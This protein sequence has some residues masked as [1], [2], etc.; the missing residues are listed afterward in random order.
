MLIAFSESDLLLTVIGVYLTLA[1]L[2]L[3]YWLFERV[4]NRD[5]EPRP[6]EGQRYEYQRDSDRHRAQA[7]SPQSART[8]Q[9]Q[10][11]VA[12]AKEPWEELTAATE[13]VSHRGDV[14]RLRQE[15]CVVRDHSS[16]TE[17]RL[18]TLQAEVEGLKILLSERLAALEPAEEQRNAFDR[19]ALSLYDPRLENYD[20]DWATIDSDLGVILAKRPDDAD[21]LTRIWGVGE[22]NQERL[23]EN[24]VYCFQQIADWTDHNVDKFNALLCFKGRIE[25]EDWIG[26]AKRLI[27]ENEPRRAA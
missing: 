16:L 14:D 11:A 24:G 18:R 13:Q 15:L 3:A 6:A 2:W 4:W 26:Q 1:V 7:A 27:A 9:S 23:N 17:S 22:V 25:R 21:D 5:D 20:A 19:P 12:A 8:R 10:H